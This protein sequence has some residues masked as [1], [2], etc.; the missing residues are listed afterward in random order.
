MDEKSKPQNGLVWMLITAFCFGTMEI[1]L[2]I[3][4]ADFTALQINFLRFFIGG[5]LLL[6]FAIHDLKKRQ[7]HLTLGDWIYLLLL[8]LVGVCLSMTIFQI[9]VMQSNANLA[10]IIIAINPVFTMIFAHFLVNDKF[11]KK[12]ALALI[13]AVI[14]LVIVANPAELVA[15][16]KLTGVILVLIASIAFGL[17]SAMSKMRIAKIGGMAQNSFSFLLGSIVELII[18]LIV[19]DPIIS[20]IRQ[21]NILVLAYIAVIVTGVGYFSFMQAID[22]AGPSRS[23]IAF[24]IKPI[25]AVILAA[26]ILSEPITWNIPLGLVFILAGCIYNLK[27]ASVPAAANQQVTE[28]AKAGKTV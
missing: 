13:L 28:D 6:P 3:G 23:S 22:K 19:G 2:K 1:A 17:Y 8:G 5:L 7:C 18:I 27:Y 20:G 21:D 24:F 10:A 25:I 9:G 15:G 11:T 26:I 4:G 12:K 16:N 14:G